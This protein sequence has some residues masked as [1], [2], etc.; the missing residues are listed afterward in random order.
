MTELPSP[1]G[2]VSRLRTKPIGTPQ[3]GSKGSSPL[4]ML[5]IFNQGGSLRVLSLAAANRRLSGYFAP[6]TPCPVGQTNMRW[7]EG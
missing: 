1:A 7:P 5:D 3:N 6:T 4:K 2:N